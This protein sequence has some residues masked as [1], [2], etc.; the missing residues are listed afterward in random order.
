VTLS[1]ADQGPGI[2]QDELDIVFDRFVQGQRQDT[3]RGSG[4]GLAIVK[5][6]TTLHGGTVTAS[7]SGVPGE[8]AV[9]I[10]ALPAG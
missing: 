9:L 4:L 8:G 5:A 3:R 7:S 2:R 10:V 6:I 1:V